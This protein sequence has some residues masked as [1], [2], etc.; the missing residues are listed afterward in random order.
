MKPFFPKARKTMLTG[1]C[2]ALALFAAPAS[3][4]L[5]ITPTLVTIEGRERY[6]DVHLVNPT[7]EVATYEIK[8]RFFRMQEGTGNYQAQDHSVTDWDLTKHIV[9][10]P[11]RVTIEPQSAQ[12]VRLGLRLAGEPPAPGDYR[13]HLEFMRIPD[14]IASTTNGTPQKEARTA[15]GV[16]VNV[17]F[18]IP[19][20]YQVGESNASAKI[21]NVVFAE[22]KDKLAIDVDVE[23]SAGPYGVS[24]D[25]VLMQ[26]GETIGQ[27]KN[28]NIFPEITKRT[29]Q[30]PLNKGEIGSGSIE[31]IYR[32][33]D[34]K[35]NVTFDRKS[36]PVSR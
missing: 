13:A 35:K 2:L 17:G 18:S 33:Q 8:W 32:D 34:L 16:K 24:G 19:I 29:F 11:R 10:T 1:A 27:I 31:V 23:R 7:A 30:V 15:V 25:L 5:S 9:F 4:N 20:I 22:R 36:V 3:A 26:N 28:A 21:T 6:A 14:P 12:K